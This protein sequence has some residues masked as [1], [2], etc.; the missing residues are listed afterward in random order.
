ME[1]WEVILFVQ[2]R[3]KSWMSSWWKGPT[4]KYFLILWSILW[5]SPPLHSIQTSAHRT[6]PESGPWSSWELLHQTRFLGKPRMSDQEGSSS[7]CGSFQTESSFIWGQ[8][9]FNLQ[10]SCANTPSKYFSFCSGYLPVFWYFNYIL[11]Y[12]LNISSNTS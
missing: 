8:S 3:S 9:K 6:H 12:N 1:T 5:I 7:H 10:P 11:Y 2:N 4:A